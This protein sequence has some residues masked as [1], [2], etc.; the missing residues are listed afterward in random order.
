MRKMVSQGDKNGEE[1]LN[2]G[3]ANIGAE[4][5]G[6]T[7]KK[8]EKRREEKRREEKRREEKRREKRKMR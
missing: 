4:V 5:E 1:S 8:K 2:G 6:E 3:V 7:L